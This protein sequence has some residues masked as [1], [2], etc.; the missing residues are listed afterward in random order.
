MK[1]LKSTDTNHTLRVIPRFNP[2]ISLTLELKNEAT[3]ATEILNL[4][5][6]FENG[7]L[8]INFDYN[9][10]NKSS[11]QFKIIQDNEII[12][13]GKLF[14]TNQTNLQDYECRNSSI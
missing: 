11:F 9:F 10:V 7:I 6:I 2:T 1:V 3:K 14:I 12:Y 5:Y 8:T 4:L 13:R